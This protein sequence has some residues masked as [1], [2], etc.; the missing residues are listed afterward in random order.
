[1]NLSIMELPLLYCCCRCCDGGDDYGFYCSR[2]TIVVYIVD[3][4]K[5][6]VSYSLD[7]ASEFIV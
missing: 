7:D 3:T 5:C 4:D 2:D 1:M 6:S